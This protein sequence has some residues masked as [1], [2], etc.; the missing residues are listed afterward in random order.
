VVPLPSASPFSDGGPP[1]AIPPSR[2]VTPSPA[3]LLPVA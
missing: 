2:G 1:S 3:T